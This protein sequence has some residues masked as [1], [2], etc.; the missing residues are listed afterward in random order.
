MSLLVRSWNVYQGMTSPHTRRNYLEQAVRLI[1]S[2]HPDVVCLQEVPLWGRR[3]LEGWSDMRLIWN[4]TRRVWFPPGLGGWIT[5]LDQG[6]FRSAVSGQ[7]NAILLDRRLEPLERRRVVISRGRR[8]RRICQ[9]VRLH[10]MVIANLHA[11]GVAGQP[12][13]G[14][15]ETLRALTFAE[16]LC[17]PGDVLI[18]AGDFNLRPKQLPDLPGFSPPGPGIDQILVRGAEASALDV[19]PLAH[20]TIAAGVL[21]DHAPVE[22]RVG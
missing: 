17:R 21:S 3:R 16:S 22:L 9:A 6:F 14:A 12:E 13:I 10:G 1:A 11:S 2:D 18:L 15:A 4:S 19:W 7:A 20:R 5:R 8:E